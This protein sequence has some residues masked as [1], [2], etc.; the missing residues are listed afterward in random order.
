[1]PAPARRRRARDDDFADA[2]PDQRILQRP[3][4]PEAGYRTGPTATDGRGRRGGGA[5]PTGDLATQTAR[6]GTTAPPDH[7][8]GPGIRTASDPTHTNGRGIRTLAR[9]PQ[10]DGLGMRAL[11]ADPLAVDESGEITKITAIGTFT[12]GAPS[13]AGRPRPVGQ[14]TGVGVP[15]RRT[16]IVAPPESRP[17]D[18]AAPAGGR[19]RDWKATASVASIVGVLALVCGLGTVLAIRDGSTNTRN[20]GATSTPSLQRHDISNR[21]ADP[22]PLTEREVFPTTQLLV[23]SADSGYQLLGTEALTDCRTAATDDLGRL[24]TQLGCTQAVR[25]TLKSPNEDYLVTAGVFNLVDEV[26]ANRAHDSI[27]GIVDSQHGR[28][29]G[30][31]SGGG[32]QAIVRAPTNL[33]WNAAGHFLAYCVIARADGKAFDAGDRNPE[34]IILDMVQTYLK[35]SVISNRALSVGQS[36]PASAASKAAG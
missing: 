36:T 6:R 28:F 32:T 5:D 16:A 17:A 31:S 30:F 4:A 33:G 3:N 27:K 23:G 1:V 10:T 19:T 24:L 7:T 15:A 18:Q 11:R 25:G 2:D 34:Q 12:T 35:D 29:T 8:Y 13:L 14:R 26:S 20:A 9:G 21:Q 22:A